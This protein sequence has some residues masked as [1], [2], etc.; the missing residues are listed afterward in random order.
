[1][2]QILTIQTNTWAEFKDQIPRM[3]FE[4]VGRK[5]GTLWFRGMADEKWLLES[6]FDRSFINYEPKDRDQIE[7][8]LINEFKK[9]CEGKDELE[10]Y[11]KPGNEEML[12]ALAQHSGLP[13]R[14]LDWSESPYI[15]A[16]FAFQHAFSAFS[17]QI[18]GTTSENVAVWALAP[19][20]QAWSPNSGVQIINMPTWG[21]I[22]Q[23]N[24]RGHFTRLKTYD[25]SLNEYVKNYPSEDPL[26]TQTILPLTEA[27]DAIA[28]LDL[29]GINFDT[30]FPDMEGRARAAKTRTL[31]DLL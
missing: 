11:C 8:N 25:N 26:L 13:T 31:I 4:G 27:G 16:F 15:A 6:S 28:D 21:N 23:Y 10:K 22:R 9:T 2:A 17:N 5:R 30:M 18:T 29:M 20:N 1:M 24:Q 7:N 3:I 19:S 12:L 14:L